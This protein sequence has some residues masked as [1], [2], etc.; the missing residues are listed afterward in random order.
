MVR[1][2]RRSHSRAKKHSRKHKSV[3]RMTRRRTHRKRG[4]EAPVNYSLAGN[5]SSRMS[6][7][8]GEDFFK[9][10]EGQHGGEAPV[11]S[12]GN[13]LPA[14]LRGPAHISGI[15]KAIMDVRGL[16]DQA[17]GKRRRHRKTKSKSKSKKSHK[18]T[19]RRRRTQRKRGGALGYAPVSAPGMLL[20]GPGAYAQAGL[21]PEWKSDVAYDMAKV[22]NTQ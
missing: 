22:R 19:H 7:G 6:L 18:K 20:S 21:N 13:M 15:D 17:G 1:K 5:W 10:H 3:R 11:S 4:G 16:S 12:I 8:Q 2:S 9:Y 14:E